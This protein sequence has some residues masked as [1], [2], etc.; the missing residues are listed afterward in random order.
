[1]RREVDRRRT[2]VYQRSLWARF[3]RIQVYTARD[4]DDVRRLAPEVADRV[5]V[6]PFAIPLPAAADTPGRPGRVAFLG[7]YRHAPNVDAAL[8]LG[9]RLMPLL[10]VR[11]PGVRLA[12]AGADPPRDVRALAC[13]D[14]EVPGYVKDADAFLG[15][16]AVVLAPVREGG[17]MRMKVLHA[18]ALERAVVTTPLGAEGLGAGAPVVVAEDDEGLA[19]ETARL[20]A[21]DAARRALAVRARAH[22]ERHHTPRS[23][24]DRLEALCAEARPCA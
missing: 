24:A 18:M 3:D 10:R 5:R 17:G 23:Y 22:V 6:N 1:V 8:R 16:A 15:E 4:A 2:P 13:A 11:H 19:R 9:R 7:N 21:D 12:L 14:I 20:L